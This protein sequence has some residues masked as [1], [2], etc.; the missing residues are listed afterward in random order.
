M[1]GPF[2]QMKT[3][4]PLRSGQ[5]TI[6]KAF[7]EQ[8]GIDENTLLQVTMVD[9]GL[10][11]FPLQVDRSGSSSTWLREL[12][13][14]FEPV[15]QEILERGISEEELFADIDAAVAES[16]AARKALTKAS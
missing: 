9:G 15:R 16:R 6:P 12:Y 3:V 8:L 13:D 11:I 7:R 10:Y 1:G 5:I 14:H 2:V 4:K